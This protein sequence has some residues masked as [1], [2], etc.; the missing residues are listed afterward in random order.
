MGKMTRE[1]FM[2]RA[3]T[4]AAAIALIPESNLAATLE[5]M[6]GKD[7]V[8]NIMVVD[9]EVSGLG[10]E[11]IGDEEVDIKALRFLYDAT[12]MKYRGEEF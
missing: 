4:G 8:A 11:L 10:W 12:E 9:G 2:K 7:F 6:K 1:E 3:V 5:Q